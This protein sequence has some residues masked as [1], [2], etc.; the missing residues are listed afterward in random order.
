MAKFRVRFPYLYIAFGF[1]AL[2]LAGSLLLILP[3]STKQG[4]SYVDAFFVSV[5]AVCI[6]GLSPVVLESTFTVFGKAVVL[7]LIQLGGLGFVTVAV[8]VFSMLGFR[9]GLSEKGDEGEHEILQQVFGRA[10]KVSPVA[11]RSR[12]KEHVV[13]RDEHEESR[14][15]VECD[16]PGEGDAAR[17]GFQGAGQHDEEPA[18]RNGG[19]AVECAAD[20]HIKGLFVRVEGQHVEAI[21]G[22][23]VG[24]TA[25]CHQ[26]KES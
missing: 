26:P 17:E 21:G 23:V 3:V 11:V 14:Q 1:F 2:I 25:E 13:G 15:Q 22:D 12:K 7:L 16:A 9:L 10:D 19:D 20:S 6:T 8:S 24:G 5:S 18:A 4:I